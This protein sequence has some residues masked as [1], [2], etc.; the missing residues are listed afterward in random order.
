MS[1]PV[2]LVFQMNSGLVFWTLF[3]AYTIVYEWQRHLRSLLLILTLSDN[4][5]GT[6]GHAMYIDSYYRADTNIQLGFKICSTTSGLALFSVHIYIIY[7]SLKF[8]KDLVISDFK[9]CKLGRIWTENSGPIKFIRWISPIRWCKILGKSDCVTIFIKKNPMYNLNMAKEITSFVLY[10]LLCLEAQSS[11][12]M[13]P[14]IYVDWKVKV[15][16][17][18]DDIICCLQRWLKHAFDNWNEEH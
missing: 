9:I 4:F 7:L 13:Y 11:K 15:N 14:W 12:W 1:S 8:Q 6:A 17:N 2:S 18:C 3:V 16:T 10:R 5:T